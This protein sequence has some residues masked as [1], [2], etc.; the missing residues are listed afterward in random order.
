[1]CL[2]GLIPV[3]PDPNI[4]VG[5]DDSDSESDISTVVPSPSLLAIEELVETS[6]DHFGIIGYTFNQHIRKQT[7]LNN[8]TTLVDDTDIF[9]EPSEVFKPLGHFY[10]YAY[11]NTVRPIESNRRLCSSCFGSNGIVGYLIDHGY[12]F[13]HKYKQHVIW[14]NGSDF[15][16]DIENDITYKEDN[17]EYF[18]YVCQMFLGSVVNFH[19][20]AYVPGCVD[21]CTECADE[22]NKQEI[23][24]ENLQEFG[25]TFSV[26]DIY[27]IFLERQ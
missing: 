18:C 11:K 5:F 17:W 13:S 2:H 15:R 16:W 19:N 26:D 12:E 14:K 8:L 10:F 22:Y 20:Y 4:V 27:S 25:H 21:Y 9:D 1:M 3:I 6:D 7:V 23:E 24:F